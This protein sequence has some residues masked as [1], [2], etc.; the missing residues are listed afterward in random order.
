MPE[1]PR[2]A[3]MSRR[4]GRRLPRM[5]TMDVVLPW[6]TVIVLEHFFST[7]AI[8]AFSLAALFPAGSILAN[9]A[10][11]RELD[12]IGA[13]VL[14]SLAT[15]IAI[16]LLTGHIGFAAVKAAPAFGLFGLASLLSSRRRRPLM[17]FVARAFEAGGDPAKRA[18]WNERLREPGFLA[19][20][21]RLSLIWGLACLAEAIAGTAGA[22]F[23]PHVALIAEPLLAF[24]TVT[25]LLAWTYSRRGTRSA[26]SNAA[27]W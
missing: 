19:V 15:G 18:D 2:N 14:A 24:V 11:H 4:N 17:F 26:P 22:F 23:L 7:T 8:L 27:I 25:G 13:A 9:W 20:M 3:S 1:R 21:Q 16:A 5:L 10:R 6:I 12:W